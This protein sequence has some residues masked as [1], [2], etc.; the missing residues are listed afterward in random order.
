MD[1]ILP[2]S[3]GKCVTLANALPLLPDQPP[4]TCLL[5]SP[6]SS[7]S[8]RSSSSLDV[9]S[10]LSSLTSYPISLLE[11][12]SIGSDSSVTSIS[13]SAPSF[14]SSGDACTCGNAVRVLR[15]FLIMD[16]STVSKVTLQAY[17]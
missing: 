14:S 10:Y 2:D 5:S 3:T 7:S 9:S 11:V 15:F 6:V 17:V 12:F 1:W 4:K 13:S 16:G 8:C